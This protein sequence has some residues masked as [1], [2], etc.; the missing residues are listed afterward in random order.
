MHDS[1]LIVARECTVVLPHVRFRTSV[2]GAG[3]SLRPIRSHQLA[4]EAAERQRALG[5]TPPPPPPQPPPH[6]EV[7]PTA[8]GEGLE[9]GSGSTSQLAAGDHC[10]SQRRSSMELLKE[11]CRMGI[12][13][14]KNAEAA[15][16]LPSKRVM[17]EDYLLA[18]TLM[19]GSNWLKV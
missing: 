12:A 1:E 8:T 5:T 7:M 19:E 14:V 17:S 10:P 6:L 4:L 3:V 2:R 15:E 16:Q 9:G 18:T 13:T 11:F